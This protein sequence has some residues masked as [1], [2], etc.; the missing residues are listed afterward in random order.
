RLLLLRHPELLRPPEHAD[1]PVR[2]AG[3]EPQPAADPAAAAERH[4]PHPLPDADGDDADLLG[5]EALRYDGAAADLAGDRFPD[6]PRQ[7][8][9]RAGA[10]CGDAARL[11]AP[12]RRP[13]FL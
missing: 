7:V 8:L 3:A 2:A 1:E 10:L 12:S 13:V 9:R 6:R 11:L 4:H 5:G